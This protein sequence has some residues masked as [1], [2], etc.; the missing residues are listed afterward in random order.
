[1][2]SIDFSH[3]LLL[4]VKLPK[5]ILYA[6]TFYYAVSYYLLLIFN[7]KMSSSENVSFHVTG[8]LRNCFCRVKIDLLMILRQA[9]R[10][11]IYSTIVIT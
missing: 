9:S 10:R 7:H 2:Y 4:H 11:V 6:K 5:E 3:K 1:M 8:I